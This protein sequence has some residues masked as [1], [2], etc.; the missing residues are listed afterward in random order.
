MLGVEAVAEGM[1]DYGVGH[2]P[3]MP[4]VSKTAQ[5]VHSTHRLENSLHVPMMTNRY[6]EIKLCFL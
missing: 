1:A 2:H 6:L 3:M 4:G 5:P